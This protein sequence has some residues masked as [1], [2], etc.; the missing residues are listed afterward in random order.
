MK[1][2]M[3]AL[4]AVIALTASA[5]S[6]SAQVVAAGP[7]GGCSTCAQGGPEYAAAPGYGYPQA[8]GHL[9]SA[10]YGV[11]PAISRLLEPHKAF[12]D[13]IA[14]PGNHK[15]MGHG[16]NQGPYGPTMEAAQ[17]GTLVFP[18]NPYIRSPRDFF[19]WEPK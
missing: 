16:G 2:L 12:I 9:H 13:K 18:Q 14:F 19:M 6:A 15:G 5:G 1:K 4:A 8:G 7:T 17:G 11:R 10:V 3:F